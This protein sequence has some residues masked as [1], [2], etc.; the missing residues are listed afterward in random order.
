[1]PFPSVSLAP[2]PWHWLFFTIG[3]PEMTTNHLDE[4]GDGGCPHWSSVFGGANVAPSHRKAYICSF[5]IARLASA[6]GEL[7]RVGAAITSAV[8]ACFYS[9]AKRNLPLSSVSCVASAKPTF[10][11]AQPLRSQPPKK[12]LLISR[13][14][15]KHSGD[16]LQYLW[17]GARRCDDEV[18]KCNRRNHKHNS[19]NSSEQQQQFSNQEKIEKKTIKTMRIPNSCKNHGD[20]LFDFL[21]GI[22]ALVLLDQ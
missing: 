9:L 22:W 17:S 4:L 20:C 21:W 7:T 14:H 18:G 1:M 3:F 13:T 5:F 2:I 16:M 10:Q 19:Y 11:P 12:T 6:K 15:V 8:V